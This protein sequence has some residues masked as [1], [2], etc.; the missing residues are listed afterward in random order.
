MRATFLV[1]LPGSGK[2]YLG[3][4]LPGVLVDDPK[5]LG[6]LPQDDHLIIADPHLCKPHTRI[7][8]QQILTTRGYTQFA[9]IYFENDPIKALANVERRQKAGDT[10]AVITF[11]KTLSPHYIIPSSVVARPIWTPP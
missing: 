3:K 4:T 11:L 9:W 7:R 6:D 5:S 1:G 10:R 8:A 2:T